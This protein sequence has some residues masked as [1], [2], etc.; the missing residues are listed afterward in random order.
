[1]RAAVDQNGLW[2]KLFGSLH[3]HAEFHCGDLNNPY[4][5]QQLLVQGL[6]HGVLCVGVDCQPHSVLGDRKGMQDRRAQSLPKSLVV[7]WLLQAAVLILEYLECT[8]E[9]LRDA[10]AQELLRQFTVDTGYRMVQSILTLGNVWCTRRDR[11]IAVLTAPI[12][13]PCDLLTTCQLVGP[14][15]LSKASLLG[16][17]MYTCAC[18][19]GAALSET[20]LRQKALVGTLLKLGTS[21]SHM[22]IT[23]EHAR[24]LHPLEMWALIGGLP[25]VFHGA[26]PSTCNGRGGSVSGTNHGA[27][28]FCP[29]EALLGFDTGS[30]QSCDP[31]HGFAVLHDEVVASCHA[32][33]P[34]PVALT[35]VEPAGVEDP[36][37][38][39]QVE[40][41]FTQ[42]CTDEPD[43]QMRLTK[44]VA[45]AQLL[46]A[47][48]GLGH[49]VE[50]C[51]LRV[52]GLSF[53]LSLPIPDGSLVALLP[54]GWTPDFLR[55]TPQV[56]CC[57][58]C[59]EVVL[60][61]DGPLVFISGLQPPFYSFNLFT[62]YVGP[63]C[64][65]KNWFAT[66]ESAP[67]DWLG[68]IDANGS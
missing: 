45:G 11:W 24:Y 36:I 54:D 12:V 68:V 55:A 9:I 14:F 34:R 21:Q 56:P 33:W 35:A 51:Q 40:C 44:G 47:E 67:P 61:G 4:V 62:H 16:I 15:K 60:Q 53:D 46:Q 6:F 10:G 39:V 28:D 18:G 64:H 29:G 58:K 38:D 20:R 25:T 17:K 31:K 22:H 13:H 1:M 59:E 3:P 32:M 48:A 27:L 63:W 19:G 2:R 42:P 65:K 37:E 49:A 43:V 26:Q 66:E 7:A 57:L 5:L 50:G 8:P 41:V 52:D 23:M 30:S